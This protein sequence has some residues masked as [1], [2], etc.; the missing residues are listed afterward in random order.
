MESLWLT[1]AKHTPFPAL[2]G[3]RT[4]E[5]LIIGGGL[6]GVL[7]AKELCEAGIDTLLV[8]ADRI[9][10]GV[11]ADTTAK[12]TFQHGLIYADL[13]RKYGLDK[14]KH[15]LNANLEA[16]ERYRSLCQGIDCD[17]EV[18]N[19]YVYSRS[20][21]KKLE[22]EVTAYH[23]LGVSARL[24]TDL[25]LP[26]PTVGAV[27]AEG[28]ASFHP[29]KFLY[30]ISA[31]LPIC[32]QTKVLEL[33][34]GVAVTN[35]GTIRAKK[36][37][38]AT[39]FP[40]LNK[41][42]GYFLK[43]YQHRSYL[44]ALQDAPRI[45]GMYVDEAESGLSFRRYRDLLL[46]V[47][48][49]HR[50]G[51]QGGNW[52]ELEAFARRHYP[53]AKEVCRFATQDCMSLDAVPYIGRYGKGTPDLYVATGFNKWGITSS[54]AAASILGDLLRGKEN[55]YAD[56]FSPSRSI[57]HPQLA[58]NALSSVLGLLTPTVPRCPHLG[59]ALKY[60]AAEHSWDCPC[61]GSRFTK[62]GKLIQNPATDDK[63]MKPPKHP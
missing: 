25:P 26:F 59:C 47:G 57:L 23:R 53:Q 17:Y 22:E 33:K 5:V 7:C 54:M 29:L 28:Q 10:H 44:L 43:L 14:A 50:T 8:E 55:R 58:L 11:T 16:L 51:K 62:D 31:G 32:E 37:L 1:T 40:L 24:V 52:N 63:P 3:D 41:H 9:G 46:L 45:D 39:H 18:Q 12:I 6:V 61:H 30:A 60:N 35:R 20:N 4:T 42:G 48:G 19:A 49:S 21:R 13:I 56:V 27:E 36:I 2:D 34:P 15:Y 38:I